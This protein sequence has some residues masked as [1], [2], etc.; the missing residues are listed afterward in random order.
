MPSDK[1]RFKN[2]GKDFVLVCRIS[3]H[4]YVDRV[5]GQELSDRQDSL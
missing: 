4:S 2:A 3:A 1:T 5:D